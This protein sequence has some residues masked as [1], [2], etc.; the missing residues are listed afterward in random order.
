MNKVKY[1]N[2]H[3]G[4]A[5]TMTALQHHSVDNCPDTDKAVGI[6]KKELIF[7]MDDL[8]C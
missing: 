2:F 6:S 5:Q 8:I 1:R 4:D 7:R 3:P